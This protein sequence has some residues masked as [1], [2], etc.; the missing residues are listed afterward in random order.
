[1]GNQT[2]RPRGNLTYRF[3]RRNAMRAMGML[4]GW[5]KMDYHTTRKGSVQHVSLERRT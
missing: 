5:R 1:M 2:K 3:A 4:R